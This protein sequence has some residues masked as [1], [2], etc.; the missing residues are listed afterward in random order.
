MHILENKLHKIAFEACIQA[1]T[2]IMRIYASP[3]QIKH[4]ED[5][6]PLTEADIAANNIIQDFLLKTNIPIVSE[7]SEIED[8]NLRKNFNQFWLV[9]P[10]DGTKEFIKKNGQFTVNIALIEQNIPVFGVVYAP[11]LQLLYMGIKGKGSFKLIDFEK[12]SFQNI[13]SA[14]FNNQK[15]RVV[16]SHSHSNKETQSFIAKLKNRFANL[17]E[18]KAGSSLKLCLLAEGSADIYPRLGPTMEWDIA[19][20]LVVAECAG[21]EVKSF[22]EK[23]DIQ[24]NKPNLLNPSFIAANFR[25]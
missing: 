5:F 23:F 20:G 21:I 8:Y 17:E 3:F 1:G 13:T 4:K 15:C 9:D 16:V 14:H 10:I 19:A 7:E 22:P 24:F 11:A 2:E 18:I 25:W 12:L 6:T